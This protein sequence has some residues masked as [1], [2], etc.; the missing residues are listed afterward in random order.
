M[1]SFALPVAVQ[2]FDK[3]ATANARSVRRGVLDESAKL[4]VSIKG[5]RVDRL[6]DAANMAHASSIVMKSGSDIWT[7]QR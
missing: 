5:R 6:S 7:S 2:R 1:A 4:G 3:L